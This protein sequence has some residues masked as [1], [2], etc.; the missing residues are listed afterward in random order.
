MTGSSSHKILHFSCFI[1]DVLDFSASLFSFLDVSASL[2]LG[3][4][5]RRHYWKNTAVFQ[6]ISKKSLCPRNITKNIALT[7]LCPTFGLVLWY[8]AKYTYL[9]YFIFLAFQISVCKKCKRTWYV[10]LKVDQDVMKID[11]LMWIKRYLN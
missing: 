3:V 7:H 4:S 5:V 2:G 1:K 6:D 8:L 10:N 11:V 9:K